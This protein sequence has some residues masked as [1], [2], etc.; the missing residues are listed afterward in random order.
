MARRPSLRGK[1]KKKSGGKAQSPN[2]MMA[3]MQQMQADMAAAQTALEDETVTITAG[4]GAISITITGQ[5]RVQGITIDPEIIDPEDAEM[6]QDMLIAGMNAAIEQSQTLAAQRM[7]G[8]TG[9]M[10]GGLQD[11]LGSLGM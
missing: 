8:I 7:E 4:G 2:A 5:Q 10:G 11:M 6:L 9:N 1:G 3:Q